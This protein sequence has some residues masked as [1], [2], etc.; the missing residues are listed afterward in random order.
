MGGGARGGAGVGGEPVPAEAAGER[1]EVARADMNGRGAAIAKG[2]GF[3]KNKK[4]KGT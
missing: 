1:G 3:G 4:K 2:L